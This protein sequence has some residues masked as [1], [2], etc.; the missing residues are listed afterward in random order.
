MATTDSSTR[1]TGAGTRALHDRFSGRMTH[2]RWVILGLLFLGTTINYVDR[3]VMGILAPDLQ[4][5]YNI[6]NVDYGYIQSAFALSY[7]F[8]QLVS[9]GLLDKFG[10][11]VGY[12]VALA[13]WSIASMLHAV[14]RGPLAF[15]IVRGLLGVSES[16]AF[17]AAA[18]TVAEW[19]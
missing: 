12:A 7:A 4:K 11:R 17:P 9:G 16:P 10:T 1:P 19:F 15:G 5:L 8:G 6:T 2:F 3:L 18:K 14:A 13:G